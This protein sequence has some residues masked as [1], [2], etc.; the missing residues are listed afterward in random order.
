MLCKKILSSPTIKVLPFIGKSREEFRLEVAYR[1]ENKNPFYKDAIDWIIN[2]AASTNGVMCSDYDSPHLV[3]PHAE[4]AIHVDGDGRTLSEKPLTIRQLNKSFYSPFLKKLPVL[5]MTLKA[6]SHKIVNKRQI[7]TSRYSD[8]ADPRAISRL[9]LDNGESYAVAEA[10]GKTIELKDAK[11]V[12]KAA[13]EKWIGSNQETVGKF[14]A[15][16]GLKM[17]LINYQG[18]DLR[19]EKQALNSPSL[20]IEAAQCL[21]DLGPTIVGTNAPSFDLQS[22]GGLCIIHKI[23]FRNGVKILVESLP[24]NDVEVSEI[25]INPKFDETNIDDVVGVTVDYSNE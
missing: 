22:E 10:T 17:V 13:V 24:I 18:Y 16:K 8:G 14:K 23:L 12:S 21:L 20:T 1:V 5:M 25:K 4:V 7:V 6:S 3:G 19:D 2:N 11:L 9:M 15:E